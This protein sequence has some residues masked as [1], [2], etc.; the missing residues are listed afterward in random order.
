MCI[1]DSSDMTTLIDPIVEALD[2]YLPGYT[3]V[4]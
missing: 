1:R 3:L 2:T 4:E